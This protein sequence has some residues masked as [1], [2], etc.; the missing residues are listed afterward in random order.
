M[1]LQTFETY[2]SIAERD[3]KD[4]T[5]VVID[6]LRATSVITTALYNGAKEVIPVSEI[7][8]A[9]ELSRNFEREGYLL[10]GERN[11]IKIEGFDLANSP[12]EY[13]RETVERKT[14][15]LATTN[16]T[17]ALKKV[18]SA[19]NIIL[20]CLLNASSVAEYIFKKNQ[21]T[22]IVCAGT[23]GKFSL[24]D[25]VTAGAI[26][27]RLKKFTEFESDDLSKASYFLYKPYEDNLYDIMK[28]GFHLN[29]LKA[30]GYEE[31]IKFCTAVDMY[32]I[33]PKYK[34]GV[35]KITADL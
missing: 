30:I 19:D 33:V 16:G 8:E 18:L 9:M 2:N 25:I 15:I 34:D 3:L 1:R 6:T 11:A 13:A 29:R 35:V 22:V 20:G 14:I 21:D 5:V 17:R 24:D 12:L 28:Y 7:E 4:K 27:K 32:N 10:G 26:Y 31:D 23:E